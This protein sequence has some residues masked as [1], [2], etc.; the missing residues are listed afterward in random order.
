MWTF[1][2]YKH[3]IVCIHNSSFDRHLDGFHFLAVV[4]GAPVS[5]HVH[6]CIDIC[7]HFSWVY[8]CKSGIAGTSSNYVPLSM[9]FHRQEY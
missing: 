2:I 4:N 1:M 8:I 6:F 9:R 5:I 3:F 7:F